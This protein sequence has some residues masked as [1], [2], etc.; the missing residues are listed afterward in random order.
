MQ[1]SQCIARVAGVAQID[2]I[3]PRE[4]GF[5]TKLTKEVRNKN[6]PELP[7]NLFPKIILEGS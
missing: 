2:H 3:A 4:G 7:K 1:T 6:A 5:R